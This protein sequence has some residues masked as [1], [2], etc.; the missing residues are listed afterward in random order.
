MTDTLEAALVAAQA[1]MP[2]VEPDATNPHFKSR[3]VSLD[4]LI[5]RTRPVL[6]KHGLAITQEPTHIDGQPALKTTIVHTSGAE[7]GDV[8]P[9]LVSK[10]DMQG[11][12]AAITYARRY[13]W[14]AVCGIV[15][16]EDDDAESISGEKAPPKS[17]E[18]AKTGNVHAS[19]EMRLRELAAEWKDLVPEYNVAELEAKLVKGQSAAWLAK[20]I[21]TY[22]ANIATKRA[23]MAKVG[24]AAASG[25]V[26]PKHPAQA[27]A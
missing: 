11:L 9:L 19:E 24:A 7:R 25:F 20:A 8:M 26:E 4:H 16:E 12:G 1:D 3:F 21:E 27:A 10:N 6:N 13:A 2:K 17:A 5:A 14:A 23:D 18:V 15:S 22:T